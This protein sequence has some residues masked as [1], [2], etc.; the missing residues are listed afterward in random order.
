MIQTP[1]FQRGA[2]EPDSIAADRLDGAAAI[3]RFWFGSASPQ[4]LK[5]TYR[6]IEQRA[7]PVGRL[8]G[9]IVGS[10]RALTAFHRRLT[11]LPA[12]AAE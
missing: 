5:R 3:S 1:R 6:L 11:D 7:I 2:P 12:D 9:R 8:G 4:N 10:R